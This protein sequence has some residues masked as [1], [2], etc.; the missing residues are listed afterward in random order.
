MTTIEGSRQYTVRQLAK[1][2]GVSVR[3]LHHYDQIGLLKPSRRSAA[4]YRLYAR[5][6]LLRLQQVL[7]YKELD[8]P[9]SEIQ[10]ILDEPGFDPLAALREHRRRLQAR[11][12]RLERLIETIDRTIQ[13]ISEDEMALTDEELYAGFSKE[14]ADRYRREA[15]ERYD[16][17]LVEES[18][19]RLKRMS[20]AQWE[21]LKQEGDEI[22]RQIAGLMD[23]EPEDP[24]VQ[25]AIAR[26][27]AMMGKFYTL[28]LEIYRG[29]GG[30]YVEHAEFRAFYEK[31]RPGLAD[32]MQAA[33]TYYCDHGLEG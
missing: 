30:L 32:F 2:A 21:A 24:D 28:T 12:Q 20:K 5:A 7:F 23:R 14:Q 15:R 25:E 31:Y 17:A 29:L 10:A 26:H 4:G 9:L 19:R 3:T 6:D 8:L 13:K 18:E 22:T 1:L 16:P 27:Y 11:R 33:M